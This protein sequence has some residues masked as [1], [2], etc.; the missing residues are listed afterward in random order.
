VA[1]VTEDAAISDLVA[2]LSAADLAA[3]DGRVRLLA[4]IAARH[5]DGHRADL[6]VAL[7]R[8]GG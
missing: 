2:G 8:S 4:Q 1:G 7:A 6:E 3:D 5:A